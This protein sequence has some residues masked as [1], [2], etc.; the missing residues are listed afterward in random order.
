MSTSVMNRDTLTKVNRTMMIVLWATTFYELLFCLFLTDSPA[1][2]VPIVIILACISVT[3]TLLHV[4]KLLVNQI[5]LLMVICC[6]GIN[7]I[8]IYLFH[9]LNGIITAYLVITVISLYQDFRLVISVAALCCISIF[10]GYTTGGENMFGSFYSTI[11]L[12]NVFFT[13]SLFTFFLS[14]LCLSNKRIRQEM[15]GETENAKNAK[16]MVEQIL[17]V[18]RD[19]IKILTQ[20]GRKISEDVL[21]TSKISGDV[22]HAFGEISTH[23][24]KQVDVLEEMSE[25]TVMHHQNLSMVTVETQSMRAFSD[26]NLNISQQ[27]MENVT[28]LVNEMAAAV[29]HSQSTV[30]SMNALQEHTTRIG[31]VLESV[32]GI[33]HQINLL[34]LNA[35]I[36]AARAGDHGKGFAVVAQE[37]GKL[38]EQSRQSTVHVSDILNQICEKVEQVSG[39]I[40]LIQGTVQTGE[41]TTRDVCEVFGKIRENSGITA[42]KAVEVDKKIVEAVNFSNTYSEKIGNVVGLSRQTADIIEAMTSN[43]ATQD[44]RIQNIRNSC[45]ELQNLINTLSGTLEK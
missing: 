2:I 35:S 3:V 32:N 6:A 17:T 7:F 9:D 14:S 8:F 22:N 27:A 25:A 15:A 44:D 18:I 42:E 16:N 45:L 28:A 31:T 30:D 4:Y 19:S 12:I 37:V 26:N 33:S 24:T 34:A 13:Y 36:E 38:A 10:Y 21:E 39:Q 20:V 29:E 5:R 41:K 11:G 23:A 1:K 43:V 40:H